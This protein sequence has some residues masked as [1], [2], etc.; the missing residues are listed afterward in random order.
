MDSYKKIF[1]NWKEK[2]SEKYSLDFNAALKKTV[3]K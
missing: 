3:L 1:H 2:N